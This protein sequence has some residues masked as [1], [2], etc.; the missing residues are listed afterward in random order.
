MIHLEFLGR[1]ICADELFKPLLYL[2]CYLVMSKDG[3]NQT[4]SEICSSVNAGVPSVD[5]W[6][7]LNLTYL[8][9]SCPKESKDSPEDTKNIGEDAC[10]F[11]VH[12]IVMVVG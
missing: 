6:N 8:H 11:T 12:G 3:R 10:E 5:E 1:F 4:C 9:E 7:S 2:H